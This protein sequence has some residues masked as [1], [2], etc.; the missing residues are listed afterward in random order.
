[1]SD[2]LY[3]T[4]LRRVIA[5][6][7]ALLLACFAPVPNAMAERGE[8]TVAMN[9]SAWLTTTD[10]GERYGPVGGFDI[11]WAPHDSWQVGGIVRGGGLCPIGER[12]HGIGQASIEGRFVFDALTWV[13]WIAIGTGVLVRADKAASHVNPLVHAGLGVDWRPSREW[14]VGGAV[15][16]HLQVLDL[17]QTIGPIELAFSA[18]FYFD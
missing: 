4:R 7:I 17:S 15:R 13:P 12:C 1:V 16:Y 18:A 9:A 8:V 10:S 2:C 11:H 3:R 14:S 5:G 6:V